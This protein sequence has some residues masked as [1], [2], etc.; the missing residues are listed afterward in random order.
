MKSDF[1]TGKSDPFVILTAGGEI[2]GRTKTVT[3]SCNPKWADESFTLPAFPGD[4]Q[5]SRDEFRSRVEFRVMDSDIVGA[6][7]FLG[8]Q[9]LDHAQVL[10]KLGEWRTIDLLADPGAADKPRVLPSADKPRRLSNASEVKKKAKKEVG[11]GTITFRVNLIAQVRIV[12]VGCFDL[13]MA[14][15]SM[16]DRVPDPYARVTY[17]GEQCGENQCF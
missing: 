2:V 11:R 7:D 16:L 15:K 5:T 9:V 12:L 17:L 4:P 8:F 10:E 6:S 3:R 14:T 1:F 13:P